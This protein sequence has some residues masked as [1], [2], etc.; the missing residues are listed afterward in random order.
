MTSLKDFAEPGDRITNF[1]TGERTVIP[2]ERE[3]VKVTWRAIVS[4]TYEASIDAA[5]YRAAV[6]A[7]KEDGWS[8]DD[9]LSDREDDSNETGYAVLESR[10]IDEEEWAEKEGQA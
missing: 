4:V 6:A 5:D 8:L 7:N 3:R 1:A 9:F 2:A 10:T